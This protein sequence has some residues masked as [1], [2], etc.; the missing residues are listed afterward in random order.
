MTR[1]NYVHFTTVHPRTDP[2]IRIKEVASVANRMMGKTALYVYDGKG[3]ERDLNGFDVIDVGVPRGGRLSRFIVGGS[4]MLFAV[5]KARPQVAHFHDPELI[6]IAIL[7]KMFGIRVIYDVHE[8]LPKQVLSKP[9]IPVG[10]RPFASWIVA[11]LERM[12]TKCFDAVV[13]AGETLSPR[14]PSDKSVV[15]HNYPLADEFQVCEGAPRSRR[16]GA[17]LVYV[18]GVTEKRGIL[19]TLEAMARLGRPEIKLILAGA[20]QPPEL[21]ETLKKHK[22]WPQ[23][24]Y[25]G[26]AD[27]NTVADALARADIGLVTL[28]SEPNYIQSYPTKMYEYMAAG[29]PFIASNFD[30][31]RGLLKGYDCCTFAD[32]ES[33]ISVAGAVETLLND[34]KRRELMA[35]EGQRAISEKFS[36]SHEEEVLVGLYQRI[37]QSIPS[38]NR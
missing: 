37:T 1:Y 16:T 11:C 35:H 38:E 26:W 17:T 9:Y 5:I 27:R 15:V 8:D 36:W 23:V 24:E 20:C 10:F 2:R 32:A 4:K 13:L 3:D 34:A 6:L 12:S 28:H 19:T 33:S 31:W 18:G 25:L 30:F 21:L 22:A 29:L 7:L 14:F